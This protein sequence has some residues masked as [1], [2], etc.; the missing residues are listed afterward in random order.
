VTDKSENDLSE[1]KDMCF[2]VRSEAGHKNPIQ[3]IA[4]AGLLTKTFVRYATKI[5]QSYKYN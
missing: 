3:L 4:I 2:P 5:Y 1:G